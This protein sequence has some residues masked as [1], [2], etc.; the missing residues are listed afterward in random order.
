MG[1]FSRF[2]SRNIGLNALLEVVVVLRGKEYIDDSELCGIP[3][4]YVAS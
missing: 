2:P 4:K 3:R 1:V